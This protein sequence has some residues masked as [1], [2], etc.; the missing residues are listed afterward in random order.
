MNYLRNYTIVPEEQHHKLL[1]AAPPEM[2]NVLTMFRDTG[3]RITEIVNAERSHVDDS[4]R[5]MRVFVP[6]RVPSYYGWQRFIYLP[7]RTANLV[8]S[9]IA[10]NQGDRVF[11]DTKGQP[12]TADGLRRQ[13]R[14]LLS[15][16]GVKGV[17]LHD[18]RRTFASRLLMKGIRGDIVSEL[19]GHV[20]SDP[21]ERFW[22]VSE[23]MWKSV[24]LG[25][26]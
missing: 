7:D 24:N 11:H 12:W 25:V 13:F 26:E 3:A 22:D 23:Q 9:L 2:A 16:A 14:R 6:D 17:A 15:A 19:L 4:D 18:Y 1:A 5:G 8:R 21:F 10:E 20:P